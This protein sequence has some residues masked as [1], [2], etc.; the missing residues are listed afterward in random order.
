MHLLR[1]AYAQATP[2]LERLEAALETSQ[3]AGEPSSVRAEWLVMQS[4]LSKMKDC[5][6]RSK[7]KATQALAIAPA[8][9]NRVQSLAYWGLAHA[10]QILEDYADAAEAYQ[11]AIHYGRVSGNAMAEMMS[12]AG[13]ATMAFER[14][15]LRVAFELASQAVQRIERA[16]VLPPI[17]AVIYGALGW[18]HYQWNQRQQSWERTQRALELSNLGGYKSWAIVGPREHKG[19]V[20]ILLAVIMLLTG[21]GFGAPIIG[22]LAGIA[23]IGAQRPLSRWRKPLPPHVQHTLTKAG[24]WVFGITAANGVFLVIGSV[25]LVYGFDLNKSAMFTNSFFFSVVSLLLT[26]FVGRVYDLQRR[27]ERVGP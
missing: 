1:G 17:S 10:Y 16:N 7:E 9:D 26:I 25:I 27:E 5:S 24:P 15:Q 18:I 20:L 23:G 6:E 19:R 8:H 2:Y 21:G 4:L 3:S 11:K 12:V 22:L 13:A 14:G